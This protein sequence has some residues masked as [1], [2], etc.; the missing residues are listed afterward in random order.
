MA[1]L[2]LNLYQVPEDE[3]DDVRALL[4]EHAIAYYET[5]PSRW[6]VSHG[7]IWVRDDEAVA[8][9]QRLMAEYQQR[10]S[11]QARQAYAA[12]V[13]EGGGGNWSILLREPWRVLLLV[14]GIAFALA[15]I[16]LPFLS[17]HG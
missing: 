8:E 10:R 14:L 12:A 7:G 3:A 1:T 2:L 16:V 4:D 13:R 17:L 6:G 5:R 11:V 9:A 15:L